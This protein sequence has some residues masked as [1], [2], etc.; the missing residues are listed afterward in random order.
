MKSPIKLQE[1]LLALLKTSAK[2]PKINP[3]ASG[4]WSTDDLAAVAWVIQD[5]VNRNPDVI[6]CDPLR[7]WVEEYKFAK[8][9]WRGGLPH[10]D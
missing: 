5:H 9:D 1:K 8:A 10:L 6:E 2:Y 7:D 4:H 3:P